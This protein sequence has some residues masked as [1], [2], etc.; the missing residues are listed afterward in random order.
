[1]T[2]YEQTRASFALDVPER[3]NYT[4]DV[5]DAWAA[6]DPDKLALIAVADDGHT[7]Q[8]LSFA[9][10]S[11]RADR[12][13]AFLSS[14]GVA[15]GDRL[16]V[17]LPRVVEWY[18]V[19]LGAFKIGAVPMPATTQLQPND[20]AYRIERSQ[21]IVAITD[22]DGAAKVNTTRERC[23]DL[24]HLITTGEP[25]GD[26]RSLRDGMDR[27]GD[28]VEAHDTAAD[29]LLLIYFTSGTTGHPKMVP[30]THASYGIG[31][32]IT[33]RFWH[34]LRPDDVHWTVSDTGWAK[35]AWGKLFG[36]WSI[37]SAVLMWN[38]QGKPDFGVMAGMIGEHGVTTF[39]A[40][41][42][43]Y[44]ALVQ[45]DLSQ[46]DFS[47]LRHCT[48]AGEPLNPET[49]TAWKDATG[50]EVHDGYGQTET[51]NIIA[52]FRCLPIKPG[53]MGKPVPG[54][55]LAVVDSDLAELEPGNEGQ[56]AVR[57]KPERPVGLFSGYW[58]DDEAN[59][60]SFR[61]DWYLTGDRAH[62]DEDGY[63][64]FV[65][66][67]DDI[68]ISAGY[69]IGPFEV[70]SAIIEHPAVAETAVIGVRDS[71]RGQVVKAFVVLAA[72]HSASDDLATEIQD[73]V[74]TVTA[75]YKYPRYVEFADELPK[76]VSGKVRRVELR[77]REGV[78]DAGA[79]R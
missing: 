21:A 6:S 51:V 31:H 69:R 32:Q 9:D 74:K 12:A 40:P 44:R 71:E 37:G 36:Q 2:D 38:P 66:R 34:D 77:E 50:T 29:D 41:P 46:Y 39:C 1:M 24:A 56:I 4:R 28:S 53:S 30:H 49:F 48:A 42:T 73:H 19:L 35:A 7:A 25:D 45:L 17:M 70:E 61:G 64:W 43:I 27:A 20:I 68:I 54:V 11:R 67:D 47:G 18:D 59:A 58:Q 62:V 26:W 23:P 52:N 22:P 8:R 60:E 57:V 3:F 10:L 33:A 13:A 5:I 15:P 76:T 79:Q 78:E 16:F 14:L 75:P 65:S 55:E 63:F 72:D